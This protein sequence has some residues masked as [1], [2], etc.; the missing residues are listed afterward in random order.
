MNLPGFTADAALRSVAHGGAAAS[1]FLRASDSMGVTPQANGGPSS[2]PP[3]P[4]WEG[5]WSPKLPGKLIKGL[6]RAGG[7][8]A[9]GAGAGGAATGGEAVAG[10]GL[11]T[12]IAAIIGAIIVG[13]AIGMGLEYGLGVPTTPDFNCEPTCKPS[14]THYV[15]TISGG[16]FG[17]DR[18]DAKA[19]EAAELACVA[20]GPSY[21]A[22]SCKTGSCLPHQVQLIN[23]L[24]GPG[25]LPGWRGAWTHIDYKFACECQCP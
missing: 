11:G 20:L 12:T 23:S 21:C 7:A 8:G 19:K 14:G 15:G 18:A 24:E 17:R 22:G 2:G 6:A 25:L 9:E 10:V 5:P 16:W 13:G 1:Q 4:P 3:Q